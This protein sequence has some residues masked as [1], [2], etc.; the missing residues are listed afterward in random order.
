M[1]VENV[2]RLSL[3]TKESSSAN[4][5]E[6]QIHIQN[7]KSVSFWEKLMQE[8]ESSPSIETTF[9]VPKEMKAGDVFGYQGCGYL[10]QND[11]ET[12]LSFPLYDFSAECVMRTMHI[13]LSALY[14]TFLHFA[15][16]HT[17]SDA[18]YVTLYLNNR[19]DISKPTPAG[20]VFPIL[21][22]SL[23]KIALS[24]GGKVRECMVRQIDDAMKEVWQ[25]I[26]PETR[27]CLKKECCAGI[28]QLG[29]FSLMCAN[30]AEIA[31]DRDIDVQKG[32]ISQGAYPILL[33]SYSIHTAYEYLTLIAGLARMLDLVRANEEVPMYVV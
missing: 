5:P 23:K 31:S 7:N 19:Y 21:I 20:F 9:A 24:K 33:Q 25:E 16:D 29:F 17:V 12:H 32:G 15:K 6:L 1:N 10:T 27:K 2:Y 26:A 4:V 11:T 3:V 14:F 8:L 18:Q 22:E 13:V 28:S 30:D